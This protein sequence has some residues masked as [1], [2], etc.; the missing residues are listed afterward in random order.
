MALV[1]RPQRRGPKWLLLEPLR[2]ASGLV[3]EVL[4]EGEG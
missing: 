4:K 1:L 3:P 2:S